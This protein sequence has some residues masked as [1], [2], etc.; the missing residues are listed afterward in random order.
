VNHP[1]ASA[2]YRLHV[3]IV[4]RQ[5]S[6]A[7]TSRALGALLRQHLH[8]GM[9]ACTTELVTSS[10][11]SRKAEAVI[12]HLMTR[13]SLWALPSTPAH[14]TR[15]VLLDDEEIHRL[16][17]GEDGA[18]RRECAVVVPHMC[19][20]PLMRLS[21]Q[22]LRHCEPKLIEHSC[23]FFDYSGRLR[24]CEIARRS[25]LGERTKV[26]RYLGEAGLRSLDC[27]RQLFLENVITAAAYMIPAR[28]IVF[29]DD[30]FFLADGKRLQKLVE[31]L[32][33]GCL[34][35]GLYTRYFDRLHTCLFAMRPQMLCDQLALFDDGENTYSHST[36]DT[37]SITFQALRKL[38]GR[39]HVIGDYEEHETGEVWCGGEVWGRHLSH[40][41][42]ELWLELP[43]V[44]NKHFRND[45]LMA[46]MGRA[47][48]DA[49]VLLE[50]LALFLG[51]EKRGQEWEPS[52]DRL[53]DAALQPEH[54]SAYFTRIY[55]NYCWLL[56]KVEGC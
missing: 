48:L 41:A 46:A 20:L 50:A 6:P 7:E 33:S 23:V 37:G 53:R 8:P 21:V 27:G 44:L 32:E 36:L 30:D 14:S 28:Y 15:E 35:S 34:L 10:E 22:N 11:V 54:F 13:E 16:A 45:R 2:R 26:L 3:K 1:D 4:A 56:Q 12:L 40:C 18:E 5:S 51:L 19:Y 47:K 24:S 49:G 55:N 39:V 25:F 43:G 38:S 31:P 9:S 52:Q 42:S 29:K 17:L